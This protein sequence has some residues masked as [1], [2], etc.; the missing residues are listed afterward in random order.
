MMKNKKKDREQERERESNREKKVPHK[1]SYLAQ[2]GNM[3]NAPGQRKGIPF[4]AKTKLAVH[5]CVF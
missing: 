2:W 5:Q 3:Q 4:A 1:R